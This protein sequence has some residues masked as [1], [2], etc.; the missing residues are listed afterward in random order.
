MRAACQIGASESDNRGQPEPVSRNNAVLKARR[1]HRVQI[2]QG[3]AKV[4]AVPNYSCAKIIKLFYQIE[5]ITVHSRK[6]RRFPDANRHAPKEISQFRK[7][8][9]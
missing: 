4:Y 3:D 7:A 2:L 6:T 1:R 5:R 8:E 9:L